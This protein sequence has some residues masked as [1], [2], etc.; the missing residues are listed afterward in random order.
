VEGFIFWTISGMENVPIHLDYKGRKLTGVADP[1]DQN[2]KQGVPTSYV[3]YIQGK[4]L[5][6][7]IAK[8]KDRLWTDLQMLIW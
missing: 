7:C 6:L 1:I 5:V 2:N 8:S 4:F 3:I